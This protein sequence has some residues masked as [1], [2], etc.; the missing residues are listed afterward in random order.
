MQHTFANDNRGLFAPDGT[1]AIAL[2]P[3]VFI[4]EYAN[5]RVSFELS[6]SILRRPRPKR[7]C[8]VRKENPKGSGDRRLKENERWQSE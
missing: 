6:K 2:S 4:T 3:P 1:A 7:K 5:E 8:D